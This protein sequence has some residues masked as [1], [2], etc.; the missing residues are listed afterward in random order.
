MAGAITSTAR[1]VG[2]AVGIAIAGGLAAGVGPTGLA[3]ASRPGWLPV[4]AC[5]LFLFAEAR[6]SRTATP[7]APGS[8]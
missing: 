4:T 2:S 7:P 3:H 1:Q 6:A 5:G 8:A